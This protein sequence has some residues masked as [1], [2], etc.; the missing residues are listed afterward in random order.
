MSATII[1]QNHE[2]ITYKLNSRKRFIVEPRFDT[3]VKDGFIITTANR[4]VVNQVVQLVGREWTKVYNHLDDWFT[5]N[6]KSLEDDTALCAVI[7]SMTY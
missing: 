5:S 4:A 7:D 6:G 1:G 3:K 2:V